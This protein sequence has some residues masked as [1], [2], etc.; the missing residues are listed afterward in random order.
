[1]TPSKPHWS[2][3]SLWQGSRLAFPER[4]TYPDAQLHSEELP[5]GHPALDAS[6]RE[7]GPPTARLTTATNRRRRQVIW[8]KKASEGRRQ[9]HRGRNS[10]PSIPP[11]NAWAPLGATLGM[12][13]GKQHGFSGIIPAVPSRSRNP[14]KERP[15]YQK[16]ADSG[17]AGPDPQLRAAPHRPRLGLSV[18]WPRTAP[19]SV[20]CTGPKEQGLPLP[21]NGGKPRQGWVGH[22]TAPSSPT[23]GEP[24]G[25]NFRDTA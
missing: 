18:C 5:S 1:M 22:S 13:T 25:S 2:R 16:S 11:S 19:G 8:E 6:Q 20:V 21:M 10:A 15:L 9:T 24:T 3:R 4:L 23:S 14:K 17:L 7:S 12:R